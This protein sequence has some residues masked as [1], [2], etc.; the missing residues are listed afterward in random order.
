[1]KKDYFWFFSLLF[2]GSAFLTSC[3]NDDEALTG[4]EDLSPSVFMSFYE[5]T[6]EDGHEV[7]FKGTFAKVDMIQKIDFLKDGEL[8]QSFTKEQIT[9]GGDSIKFSFTPKTSDVSKT[10]KFEPIITDISGDQPIKQKIS[11]TVKHA[12]PIVKFAGGAN[13]SSIIAGDKLVLE[14]SFWSPTA[15]T[16][17]SISVIEDKKLVE[18]PATSIDLENKTFK[19]ERPTA[20]GDKN[21]EFII[22]AINE[23]SKEDGKDSVKFVA[24]ILTKNPVITFGDN[25]KKNVIAYTEATVDGS[26]SVLEGATIDEVKFFL[27][28]EEI[29][30]GVD[31]DNK[32]S[33]KRTFAEE[34]VGTD[35]V[36]T[37]KAKATYKGVQYQSEKK[38]P[39]IVATS[40]ATTTFANSQLSA[41]VKVGS[42]TTVSGTVTSPYDLKTIVLK[43]GDVVLTKSESGLTIDVSKGTFSYVYKPTEEGETVFTVETEN[44]QTEKVGKGVAVFVVNAIK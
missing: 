10:I 44:E 12:K 27:G 18:L 22:Q 13:T 23:G 31:K 1:M 5:K 33:I 40:R 21:I 6:V 19:Y 42:E 43:K 37:A 7:K 39:I 3:D 16:S 25:D 32:I 41:T 4:V 28:D 36:I 9:Q 24:S 11:V 15:L 20:E 35:I 30:S 26:V 2:V 8:F 34:A 17:A 38:L 29:A 14:G